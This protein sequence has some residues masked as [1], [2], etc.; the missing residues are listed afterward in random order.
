[1]EGQQVQRDSNQALSP[2]LLAEAEQHSH[3]EHP[4]QGGE[5]DG[6]VRALCRS[7]GIF[8]LRCLH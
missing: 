4:Q 8:A 5:G 7:G 6:Q 1:M 2:E 3:D